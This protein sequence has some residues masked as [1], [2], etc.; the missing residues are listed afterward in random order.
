LLSLSNPIHLFLNGLFNH[1]DVT[2]PRLRPRRGRAIWGTSMPTRRQ[3]SRELGDRQSPATPRPQ[4]GVRAF[5]FMPA[6]PRHRRSVLVVRPWSRR[7]GGGDC[8]PLRP[9]GASRP[10]SPS[11]SAARLTAQRK[12]SSDGRDVSP[13]ARLSCSFMDV[14]S[15]Q[16]ITSATRSNEASRARGMDRNSPRRS[17]GGTPLPP[18]AKVL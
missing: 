18:V 1:A 3:P 17:G 10:V 11:G 7:C 15:P 9:L 13:R 14:K 12:T 16:L 5:G 6:P 4:R 2:T 8:R